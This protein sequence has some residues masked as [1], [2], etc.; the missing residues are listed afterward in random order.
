MAHFAK[1]IHGMVVDVIVAEQDFIDQLTDGVE[2]TKYIQT[3]YNTLGGVHLN[4]G[5][6]LR[7]NFASV[8]YT[9]DSENDVFYAPKPFD[10]WVLNTNTWTW[11]APVA[12]PADA[13]LNG[14][15]VMYDWDEESQSWVSIDPNEL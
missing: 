1:V 15:N 9:Y 7:G 6:P 12:R 13:V 3:S 4:G 2:A 14:G 5:T 10:S 11:E 8:G